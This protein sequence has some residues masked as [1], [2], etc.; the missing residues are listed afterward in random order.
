[1][2]PAREDCVD[3]AVA[4]DGTR[5]LALFQEVLHHDFELGG[6]NEWTGADSQF[7]APVLRMLS[8][9]HCRTAFPRYTEPYVDR[10][11]QEG[12]GQPIQALDVGCGAVSRLR[13]AALNGF[14]TL[15][16]VDPLLDMYSIV[17]ERH[18]LNVLA[19]IRCAREVSVGAECLKARLVPASF[20]F[21]YC[22]NA[23]DHTE[24]PAAVVESIAYVL[25]PG[26][27]FALEV[28]TREASREN[29]WQLHQFDMYVDDRDQFVCETRD[30]A[31]QVLFPHGCGLVV[32]DI[33]SR[34][35]TTTALVAERTAR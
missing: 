11:W 15:T 20:D 35:A 10:L 24:N 33:V 9:A 18:G 19:D 16:G 8:T 26:G 4:F 2:C 6:K 22:A 13:W 27:I 3:S 12:G 29:W 14:M 34:D 30:G 5:E 23:L 17:R 7:G 1:M 31:V 32:R 28:Y 25:R 21:A